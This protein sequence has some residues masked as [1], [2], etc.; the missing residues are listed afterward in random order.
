MPIRF[1]CAY[2]NQL[3]GISTR[4]AGTVVRCPKCAGE[5]IV[6]LPE[7]MQPPEEKADQA[8][9]PQAFEDQNFEQVFNE[10]ANGSAAAPTETASAPAPSAEAP[11]PGPA[12]T[13][14]RPGLF[15]PLGM[16]LVSLGVIVLL[17]I[18]MFVLGLIIGRHTMVIPDTKTTGVGVSIGHV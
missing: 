16:L 8:A 17:L 18:L 7:G 6:P 9:G 15:L 10:P 13:P 1:R 11:Q 2:C 14:K 12:A 4:K 3:M 5:I